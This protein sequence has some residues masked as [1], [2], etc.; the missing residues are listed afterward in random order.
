MSIKVYWGANGSYKSSSAVQDDVIPELKKGRTV[1]TNIRGLTLEKCLTQYPDLPE[2]ANIINIDMASAG[3]MDKCRN[4]FRWAPRGSLIVLDEIQLI[5]PT[6]WTNKD[7]KQ[8]E[9]QVEEGGV[10]RVATFDE[11]ER[12][13]EP[14]DM[15]DAFT[16]HR[17]FN[18]D[19]VLTTPNIK[20]VRTEIR[21][22]TE[23]AYRQANGALLGIKG[24]FKR[25]LHDAQV[26]QPPSG[27]MVQTLKIN[28]KTFRCYS[29]TATGQ[30]QD[31]RAGVNLF[32]S[33]QLLL[34]LAVAAGALFYSFS[35]GGLD[36]FFE[37]HA[38]KAQQQLN[39]DSEETSKPDVELH[40][41]ANPSPSRVDSQG[42]TNPDRRHVSDN[43][44]TQPASSGPA[45][46]EL[47]PFNEYNAH[48]SRYLGKE[49]GA[50]MDFLIE[51][52]KDQDGHPFSLDM[53]KLS[54][55]GYRFRFLDECAIFLIWK[56]QARLV[57]CWRPREE[58]QDSEIDT[59]EAFQLA[60]N[61]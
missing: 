16:R 49:N 38:A 3:S 39:P 4:W 5:Y 43:V 50:N 23:A 54:R 13:G 20:Y 10:K 25:S 28:Q 27:A 30:V 7:L 40:K 18:W 9:L 31:T 22:T 14:F 32:K 42:R 12:L 55:I 34:A 45:Y 51:F 56:D 24:R 26:N 1:I 60:S 46:L 15:V 11:A 36:Y 41:A 52:N 19:L 44:S 2:G 6:Q 58:E 37:D 8:F 61:G 35:S 57:T 47:E 21:Q 29:S 59:S 33:P 48:I 17:H 53:A